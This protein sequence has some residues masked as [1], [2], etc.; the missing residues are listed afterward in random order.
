MQNEL[1]QWLEGGIS[2]PLK[3]ARE[4]RIIIRVPHS[5]NFDY[6]FCQRGWSKLMLLRNSKFEY[7]GIY[8]I[9]TKTLYDLQY[10]LRE[11]DDENCSLSAEN[12][13]V[14]LQNEVRLLVEETLGNDRKNLK[15]TE[16]KD[17]AKENFEHYEKYQAYKD[18][19]ELFLKLNGSPMIE[20]RY[21]IIYIST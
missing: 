10:V 19:R 11:F 3:L 16:L 21:T 20:S 5:E 17:R 6:L 7:A 15:I 1:Q 8:C 4:G 2:S 13:K 18:A 12:L 9:K 14:K